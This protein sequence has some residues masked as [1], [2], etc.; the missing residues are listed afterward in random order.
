MVQPHYG[1]TLTR[2]GGWTV[3]AIRECFQREM[4]AEFGSLG[5]LGKPYP[6]HGG[7]LP[8]SASE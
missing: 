1:K 7:V 8:P 6:F 5:I 4:P 2:E 3:E